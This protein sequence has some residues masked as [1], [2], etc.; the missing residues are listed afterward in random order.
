M[1][2]VILSVADERT[3][4]VL[5][6]H[7]GNRCGAVLVSILNENGNGSGSR[8]LER[9]RVGCRSKFLQQLVLFVSAKYI[10]L[11]NFFSIEMLKLFLDEQFVK[12]G[13]T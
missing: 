8:Q 10:K 1:D 11:M 7:R 6:S 9:E 12:K 3:E 5:D 13:L 2:F 4:I